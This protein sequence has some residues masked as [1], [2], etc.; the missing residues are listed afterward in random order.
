VSSLLD[1]DVYEDYYPAFMADP[2]PDHPAYMQYDLPG[3]K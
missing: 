2:F 3:A 1:G